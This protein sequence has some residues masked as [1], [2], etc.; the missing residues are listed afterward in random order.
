MGEPMRKS[1]FPFIGLMIVFSFIHLDADL[2]SRNRAEKNDKSGWRYSVVDLFLEKI[3]YIDNKGNLA[4]KPRFNG[5]LQ[6]V[7]RDLG[8]VEINGKFGYIDVSG[9]LVIPARFDSTSPFSEGLALIRINDKNGYINEKGD[10]VFMLDFWG[11]KFSE[12]LACI[13]VDKDSWGFMDKRGKLV[14]GPIA[15]DDYAPRGAFSEGLTSIKK[16]DKFG[17]MNKAGKIVIEPR[18]DYCSDFHEGLAYGKMDGSYGYIDKSGEIIIEPQFDRVNDFSEG[19]AAVGKKVIN[20]EEIDFFLINKKGEKLA[21]PKR[22]WEG[23]GV[24]HDGLASVTVNSKYGLVNRNFE[25][26]MGPIYYSLGGFRGGIAYAQGDDLVGY[27]DKKGNWI[28]SRPEG[29]SLTFFFRD[30]TQAELIKTIQAYEQITEIKGERE[31]PIWKYL[32]KQGVLLRM[33]LEDSLLLIDS[34]INGIDETRQAFEAALY[35]NATP[36]TDSEAHRASAV[37]DVNINPSKEAEEALFDFAIYVFSAHPG[38]VGDEE[39]NHA[40]TL[41]EIKADKTWNGIHFLKPYK[42]N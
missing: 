1:I 34:V 31:A 25:F 41:E 38:V 13:G 35:A 7:F 22:G 10:T 32:S 21:G 29:R 15:N 42:R 11:N 9:E 37:L 2:I 24:F 26:V 17:Y 18:F 28:W 20:S 19:V 39:N 36:S 27:I 3:G 14:I 30:T 23:V 8:W 40:W 33:R 4:I 5:T 12:G 6:M 16:E